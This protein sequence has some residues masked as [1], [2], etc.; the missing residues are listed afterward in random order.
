MSVEKIQTEIETPAAPV[1][2]ES[3]VQFGQ[4]FSVSKRTVDC[5]IA[6]G[7]PHLKLSARLTRIPVTEAADWIKQNHLTQRQA[8]RHEAKN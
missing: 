5:W 8:Q 2:A 4:R 1:T 6:R 7:L 3:K